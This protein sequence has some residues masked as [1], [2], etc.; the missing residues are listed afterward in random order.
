MATLNPRAR[1]VAQ[2]IAAPDSTT[3]AHS[4]TRIR[5]AVVFGLGTLLIIF[6]A[7]FGTYAYVVVQA[8]I[9]TQT[10]LLRGPVVLLFFLVLL[11][12]LVI[13]LARRWA[14]T[15]AEL[16]LLYSMLC[17]GTCAAGYG[18]V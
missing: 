6:N 3:Q 12:L 4:S 2:P 13:R 9:W 16:L 14:L 5:R 1:S 11:N 17:L 15:Q 10:A 7:Y 18:F 8:L